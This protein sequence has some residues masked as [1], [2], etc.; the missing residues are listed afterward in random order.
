M[1]EM[2]IDYNE[3]MLNYYPEVIKAIRE[4]RCLIETQ[5]V[6]VEDLHG[7]LVKILTN[8]YVSTADEDTI[9][10]WEKTLDITPLPQRTVNYEN[11]LTERRDT[12]LARLHNSEKLNTQTISNIVQIFTGGIANSYFRDGTI[13]VEITPPPTNKSYRFE[14]VEQELKYKVPAHLTMKVSRNYYEWQEVYDDFDSWQNLMDTV[15]TWEDAY[16]FTPFS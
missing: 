6:E 13:Y 7:E 11:W 14:A 3:Q 8:A 4:F 16:L 9:K 15:D 2:T 5:A 1:D 12:I 10:R